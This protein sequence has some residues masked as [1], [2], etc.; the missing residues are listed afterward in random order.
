MSENFSISDCSITNCTSG[1]I[2]VINPF[3]GI[4]NGYTVSGCT[5]K[6]SDVGLLG[7]G[8]GTL[9]GNTLSG[10]SYGLVLYDMDNSLIYGN[11]MAQNSLAGIAFDLNRSEINSH[12][13]LLRSVE[14]PS[15]GNNTIYNNYFNNVNNTLFYSESN[16]TWNASK[17]A[18]KN[19]IEGPYLGGN[20]WANP[21]GTGFSENCTD[22]N[23]DGISDSAYEIKNGTY[24]YLPL[25]TIPS[26]TTHRSSANYVPSGGSS[27]ITGIDN[28]QKRVTAGTQATFSFNNPVSG[29]MGLSFT[30]QQYS[31]NVIV[32]I[33]VLG[34]GTSGERPEGQLYQMMN[35]LVGNERFE[36]GSNINGANINFRVAKSWVKENNID[37]STIKINRLQNEKWN[38][39]ATKMAYEDEEY[40]Y[41]TAE[42]PGFSRYAITGD[43]ISTAVITPAEKDENETITGEEQTTNVKRRTPGFEGAFAVLGVF[44]SA[45]FARKKV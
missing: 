23:R 4:G 41:F 9:S 7:T 11:T 2:L 35:V 34:D 30:S 20:Y 38:P 1:G 37:I 16:N 40:Y 5:V 15:S 32:R 21:S 12:I 3:K 22:A 39:L 45:L 17:T 24:D 43:K 18:G 26:R 13:G 28:A 36:S 8:E 25:T 42:T 14:S 19:I 31:G 10:N 33:E 29:I 6:E 27:G 44:A